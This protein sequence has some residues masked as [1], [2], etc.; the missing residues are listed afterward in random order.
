[1]GDDEEYKKD[2]R[3]SIASLCDSDVHYYSTLLMKQKLCHN[4]R[5]HFFYRHKKRT[6]CHCIGHSDGVNQ[7]KGNTRQ[8]NVQTCKAVE[9]LVKIQ[10]AS[11]IMHIM[12]MCCRNAFRE[13]NKHHLL[14]RLLVSHLAYS[15]IV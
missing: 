12:D 4:E 11:Y 10:K 9:P 5:L 14:P 7:L 1:M 8:I 15:T 2:I 13:V 3:I 6:I